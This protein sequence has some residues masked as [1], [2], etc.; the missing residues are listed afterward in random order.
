[1]RL[2]KGAPERGRRWSGLAQE[3]WERGKNWLRERREKGKWPLVWCM[4]EEKYECKEGCGEVGR[5]F[6]VS[7]LLYQI[8]DQNQFFYGHKIS[9]DF[10]LDGNL[11]SILK[12]KG[13]IFS[14]F[15]IL[16]NVTNFIVV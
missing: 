16:K 1:M 10:F 6:R 15:G 2:P 5:K 7:N 9:V 3:R 12:I 13:K 8:C 14:N 11:V 4:R